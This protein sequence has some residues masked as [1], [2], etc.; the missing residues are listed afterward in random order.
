[1]TSTDKCNNIVPVDENEPIWKQP[2]QSSDSKALK[3]K[4][5]LYQFELISE[6]RSKNP[7]PVDTMGARSI[8]TSE[9]ST[10]EFRLE[11]LLGCLLSS[12][13]KD[14]T[15]FAAMERLKQH[16]CTVFNLLDDKI[17]PIEKLV[18][19]IKPVT[20]YRAK[21]KNIKKIMKILHE[22]YSDDIPKTFEGLVALPGIGPKMGNLIMAIAWDK[23]FGISVDIHVHRIA[24]R[25]NWVNN[26]PNPE[27]TRKALEEFVPKDKCLDLNTTLVGFGQTICKQTPLCWKCDMLKHELCP[28]GMKYWNSVKSKKKDLVSESNTSIGEKRKITDE[29]G[30]DNEN[31]DLPKKKKKQKL[32]K[33]DIRFYL[34]SSSNSS[35]IEDIV[36]DNS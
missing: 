25:L 11:T 9:K 32:N 26:T 6:M 21:A 27:A 4:K 3:Q 33:N 12:Q 23:P 30:V 35:D 1:M 5:F 16:G 8:P 19:L 13:T 2:F 29:T 20:F 28:F 34:G 18:S 36:S 14:Q 31:Q 15:T 24:N 7:A 10:K 22:R 17:T